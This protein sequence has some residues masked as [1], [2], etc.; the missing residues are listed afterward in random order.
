MRII[1]YISVFILTAMLMTSCYEEYV[2]DF[3]YTA[4][5]FGS[6]KPLRTIVADDDMSFEVG[7]ALGGLRED[8]GSHEVSFMV[9][10]SLMSDIV[11]AS[12]FKLLPENYYTLSN[13]TKFDIVKQHM[14]VVKVTLDPAFAADSDAIN[15]TYVLPLRI[16]DATVDS[17]HGLNSPDSTIADLDDLGNKDI[18][19]L[20]VKYISPYSGYYYVKGVQYEI[21]VDGSYTDTL[22]YSNESLSQNDAI[23]LET[24][25]VNVVETERIGDNIPGTFI[26]TL[27]EDGTVSV[28]SDNVTIESS[29]VTY[30]ADD[31]AFTIEAQVEYF[32]LR[33]KV[34]DQLILRQD[35]ELDLRFEEW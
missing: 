2:K 28:T 18:T 17:I 11:E 30:S 33:Y 14:R 8:D 5:Y 24:K 25:G 7:V 21:G 20:V 12:A 6:Q 32:G 9:D 27:N 26:L 35:P 23:Y 10:T 1:K 16:T 15:E 22:N 31:K 34:E 29:T 19:L 13:N 3:E 4:T